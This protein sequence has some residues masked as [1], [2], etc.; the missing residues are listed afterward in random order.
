MS[1]TLTLRLLAIPLPRIIDFPTDKS[2]YNPDI[3]LSSIIFTLDY[4]CG[5]TAR[6]IALDVP[7]SE[8]I[9]A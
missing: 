7:D 8:I 4:S 2:L 6:I 3:M 9:N 1:P 5:S